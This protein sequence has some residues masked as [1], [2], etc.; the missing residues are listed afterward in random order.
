MKTDKNAGHI[1][2]YI[3]DDVYEVVKNIK[4]FLAD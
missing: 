3:V 4:R 2:K 1:S